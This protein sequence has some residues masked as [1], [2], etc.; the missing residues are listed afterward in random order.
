[1]HERARSAVIC[2]ASVDARTSPDPG[3]SRGRR[4]ALSLPRFRLLLGRDSPR[5][6]EMRRVCDV[7]RSGTRRGVMINFLKRDKRETESDHNLVTNGKK[8]RKVT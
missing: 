3:G 8:E 6:G 1:M 2:A 5:E 7:L 4:F